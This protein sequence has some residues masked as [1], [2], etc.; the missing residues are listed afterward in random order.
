M[1][2]VHDIFGHW[3]NISEFARA[4]GVK[5]DTAR[6]WKKFGRIPQEYWQDVIVA[7]AL[8]GLEITVRDI[9]TANAPMK[10]RGRPIGEA[11]AP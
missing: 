7:M 3:R 2:G 4:V 1:Q 6:K 9:L 11:R 10:R 8:K 5:P